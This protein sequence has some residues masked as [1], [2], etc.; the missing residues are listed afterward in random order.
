M[1]GQTGNGRT[2]TVTSF[3]LF[4][5]RVPLDPRVHLGRYILPLHQIRMRSG[6]LTQL[7]LLLRKKKNKKI[8]DNE[9]QNSMVWWRDNFS[10]TVY[11]LLF[12]HEWQ[13]NHFEV[14]HSFKIAFVKKNRLE[15]TM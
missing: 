13:R 15:T 11:S 2:E 14:P 12:V 8:E 6:G 5:G 3:L 7:S 4:E 9:K 10:L 1:D